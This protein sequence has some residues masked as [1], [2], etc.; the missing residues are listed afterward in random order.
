MGLDSLDVV[1]WDP[2]PLGL[3]RYTGSRD[4]IGIVLETYLGL[5]FAVVETC[6]SPKTVS[7]LLQS[8]GA[9]PPPSPKEC[10]GM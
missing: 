7:G 3:P 2:R 1:M 8:T 4:S 10:P 6:Q 9:S 5:C